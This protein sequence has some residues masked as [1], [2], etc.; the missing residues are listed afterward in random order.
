MKIF[1]QLYESIEKNV[2]KKESDEYTSILCPFER[3]SNRFPGWVK[4]TYDLFTASSGMNFN[5]YLL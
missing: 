2:I 1:N 4:G 3:L 5:K